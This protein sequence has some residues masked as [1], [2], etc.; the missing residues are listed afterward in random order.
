MATPEG[1]SV[2]VHSFFISTI[3]ALNSVSII[4]KQDSTGEL[5]IKSNV[6]CFI[7]H[8]WHFGS[9]H[10]LDYYFCSKLN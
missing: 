2:R 9:L 10:Y 4:S 6:L 8:P 7:F 3:H 5:Y 1:E